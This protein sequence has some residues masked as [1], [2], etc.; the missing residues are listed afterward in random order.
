PS[1]SRI[2]AKQTH[3]QTSPEGPN[4]YYKDLTGSQVGRVK[5]VAPN[6]YGSLG[7]A[8]A[9]GIEDNAANGA[10]GSVLGEGE[11]G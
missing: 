5:K 9:G 1:C 3:P 6:E 8:A 10:G 4:S 7:D 2:S 11:R